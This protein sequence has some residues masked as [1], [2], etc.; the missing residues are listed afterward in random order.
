[1]KVSP[2]YGYRVSILSLARLWQCQG[3]KTQAQKLLAKIY[4]WFTNGFG[5]VDLQEAKALLTE[6]S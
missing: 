4:D 1:V 3:K 5:T 2:S 6:L